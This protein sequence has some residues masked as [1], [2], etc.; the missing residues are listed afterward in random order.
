MNKFSK[1][2]RDTRLEKGIDQK[3][4]AK[5]LNTSQTNVSRWEND[6]FQPDIETIIAIAK[7]FNVTTD[8]LLGLTDY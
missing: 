1:R 2:L 5:A 3:T 8:Y 7:F 4:L 6:K